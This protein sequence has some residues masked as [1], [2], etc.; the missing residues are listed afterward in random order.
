MI[1]TQRTVSEIK[2]QPLNLNKLPARKQ[3]NKSPAHKQKKQNVK[4]PKDRSLNVY[5]QGFLNVGTDAELLKVMQDAT[6]TAGNFSE[7]TGA[8][9]EA[10]KLIAGH[11]VNLVPNS[12]G[13]D[14][15]AEVRA[16][17]IALEGLSP[18]AFKKEAKNSFESIRNSLPSLGMEFNSWGMFLTGGVIGTGIMAT[19]TRSNRDILMFR[20]CVLA[21]VMCVPKINGESVSHHVT[22][23]MASIIES[24]SVSADDDVVR[25]QFDTDHLDSICNAASVF[26]LGITSAMAGKKLPTELFRGLAS[27]DRVKSSLSSILAAVIKCFEIANNW[28]RNNC[29]DLPSESFLLTKNDKVNEFILDIKKLQEKDRLGKLYRNA[30]NYGHIRALICAGEKISSAIPRDS[31]SGGILEALRN[32][33]RELNSLRKTFEVSNFTLA[34]SRQEPV[35]VMLKGGPGTGKSISMEHLVFAICSAVL[36][37]EELEAF[38]RNPSTFVFNRQFENKYWDGYNP[39]KLITMFD[40]FGQ[41]RDVAGNPDGE[42][43][44]IIRAGSG[45]EMN[46]HMA[47]MSQ[48]GV[49]TFRSKFIMATT[50]MEELDFE[51]I[52]S[53]DALLRRW[54]HTYVVTPAPKYCTKQTRTKGLFAQRVDINKLPKTDIEDFDTRYEPGVSP[55]TQFNPTMQHF[56]RVD[57]MSQKVLGGD[58][59]TFDEVVHEVLQT[60]KI[61]RLRFLEQAQSFEATSKK[62]ETLYSDPPTKYEDNE[63][64]PQSGNMLLEDDEVHMEEL[65]SVAP[66]EVIDEGFT[67]S[68]STAEIQMALDAVCPGYNFRKTPRHETDL[69]LGVNVPKEYRTLVKACI[70]HHESWSKPRQMHNWNALETLV[71]YTFGDDYSPITRPMSLIY[72]NL[73]LVYGREFVLEFTRGHIMEVQHLWQPKEFVIPSHDIPYTALDVLKEFVVSLK[74]RAVAWYNKSYFKICFDLIIEYKYIILSASGIIA[75]IFYFNEGDNVNAESFGHSDRL[76][77]TKARTRWLG[78]SSLQVKQALSGAVAQNGGAYDQS[79]Q[80]LVYSLA[81]TCTYQLL[82]EKGTGLGTYNRPGDVFHLKGSILLMPYHFYKLMLA[83]V[84]EDE[85]YLDAKVKLQRDGKDRSPSILLTIKDFLLGATEGVLAKNDLIL[86]DLGNKLQPG[87]DKVPYFARRDDYERNRYNISY[88]MPLWDQGSRVFASGTAFAHDKNLDVQSKEVGNYCVR[89][90]YSYKAQTSTGDCGALFCVLNPSLQ[91]R[92]IFGLHIAGT[93]RGTGYSGV[94]CQEDLE[95]DLK[96]FDNVVV[97]EMDDA[98]I[99]PDCD[100]VVSQGQF[101]VLGKAKQP[102]RSSTKTKIVKSSLHGTWC[103][104]TTGTAQ[105]SNVVRNGVSIRPMDIALAKYCFPPFDIPKEV[106]YSLKESYLAT[107]KDQIPRVRTNILTLLEA[108]NGICDDADSHGISA[109]TSA[110]Y[111]MSTGVT[112]NWK[113]YLFAV[114]RDSSDFVKRVEEYG[115]HLEPIISSYK[116]GIRPLWIF[117]DCLKDERRPLEK[118]ESGNTRLFSACPFDY[119]VIFKMYFGSFQLEFMNTRI[120]NGSAVGVNPYSP[121]WNDIAKRLGVFDHGVPLVGAGDFKG[122]DGKEKPPIHEIICEIINEWYSDAFENQQIRHILWRDVVNSRHVVEGIVV[123]WNSSLPSGHPYTI[124]INCMYNHIAFR[125]CWMKAGYDLMLF[126]ESV[127]LIVCGDDNLFSVSDFARDNFNEMTIAE[128]MRDLGLE[129]TTEF[130]GTAVIPFRKLTEIEFL[131][132]GFRHEPV[133]G[134]YVAPLRLEVVLEIP[135]WTKTHDMDNITSSNTIEAL[136]ELSLHG[137]DTYD[138]WAPKITE[139]FQRYYPDTST[140]S[141][142]HRNHLDRLMTVTGL[143]KRF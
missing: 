111:P 7:H 50:N 15:L 123:E 31:H 1:T 82:C 42:A 105:L 139:Q 89:D 3:L 17:R 120:S 104:A 76:K 72:Y 121:E 44:N 18:I 40:D 71:L 75:A 43:A 102:P 23:F 28:I 95:E 119:L 11:A 53:Q 39:Q 34:G 27:L 113:K 128:H 108:L 110:G 52:I 130:K 10:V 87:A 68:P 101:T 100:A 19:I 46:L 112:F 61:K 109:S 29:F 115:L 79:G 127:Y 45:F 99:D 69:I 67:D 20:G 55:V 9:V 5:P 54:D 26:L 41:M 13:D 77:S 65:Y 132:R 118:C 106:L 125:Y 116:N 136:Q 66:E 35:G 137:K 96:L 91:K 92:K 133:L 59:L 134:R 58:P 131:K 124:I 36:D 32:V 142:L 85:T 135:F 107:V 70:A 12:S 37:G 73:I 74:N 56:H 84:D 57:K 97:S 117:T 51:S 94:V 22:K 90:S 93:G 21:F 138:C 2:I 47:E 24:A 98:L 62:Y 8:L 64:K 4:K 114:P 25:P 63:I 140:R 80:N 49:S 38:K 143:L 78:K 30:E 48:K 126:D 122:Y 6:Q 60:Y 33:L 86:V 83:C 103:K 141:S 16:L 81:R 88:M 129:Y 14:I